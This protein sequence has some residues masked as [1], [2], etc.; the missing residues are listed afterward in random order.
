MTSKRPVRAELRDRQIRGHVRGFVNSFVLLALFGSGCGVGALAAAACLRWLYVEPGW[1]P[2]VRAIF[3]IPAA[4]FCG[5]M[6]GG[7]LLAPVRARPRLVPYFHKALGHGHVAFKRGVGLFHYLEHL[8]ELAAA[9]GV[10]PLS[11]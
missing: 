1:E 8:D 6:F 2:F 11:D 7:L 9:E 5:W 4:G 3:L 10:V